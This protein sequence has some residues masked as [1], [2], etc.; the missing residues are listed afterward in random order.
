M[1]RPLVPEAVEALKRVADLIS[2]N[3]NRIS[4]LYSTQL[5]LRECGNP[6][7]AKSSL[8]SRNQTQCRFQMPAF[9]MLQ[10]PGHKQFQ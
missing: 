6:S 7:Q 3:N 1:A 8:K 4:P 10:A 2:S 9:F 5:D